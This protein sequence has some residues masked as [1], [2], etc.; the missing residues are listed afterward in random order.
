[1]RIFSISIL[2]LFLGIST[3]LWCRELPVITAI[4]GGGKNIDWP[5][6]KAE[7][8][9]D[10]EGP[11]FFYR[12]CAQGVKATN[13]SSTLAAQGAKSYNVSNLSDNNPMTA[14]VEGVGGYGIGQWFEVSAP[15]VNTI[16]NGYQATTTSWYNNSRVKRFKVYIDGKAHCFLDLTDEM[17]AQSFDLGEMYYDSSYVFRFEIADVY[18]GAK[19]DDVAIS[20]VDDVACCFAVNTQLMAVAGSFVEAGSL[21]RGSEIMAYDFAADSVYS[22]VVEMKSTQKHITLLHISAGSKQIDVTPDHPLYVKDRGFVSMNR[23][24]EETPGKSY[25]EIAGTFELLMWDAAQGASY[26]ATVESVEVLTGDFQTVTVRRL[27]NGG[28][29]IANGFVSKTY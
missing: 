10:P 12:D 15:R 25:S 14:W 22:S 9:A 21:E 7:E 24:R 3:N 28:M 2:S 26:F 19:W 13:A 11:G 6:I 1:M 23:L 18:K 8:D 17:G 16:Y 27:S 20:H 4:G 5:S 29:Y